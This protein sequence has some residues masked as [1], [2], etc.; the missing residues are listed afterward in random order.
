LRV[1]GAAQEQAAVL[2]GV[3]AGLVEPGGEARRRVELGG[4]LGARGAF[5]HHAGVAA[6]AEGELQR[7]DEDR[8][9][10]AGLAGEH[11]EAASSSTSS[12]VTM[13]KSRNA[14]RRSINGLPSAS[15]ACAATWRSSS[16]RADAGS[17]PG[18]PS[19]A[20]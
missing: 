7:V 14:R 9:A 17:A 11:G 6:A 19:A 10:G 13:T 5:A 16:S 8:L 1:D 12:A 20:R 2:A 15:A 3:E 4:D 18:A